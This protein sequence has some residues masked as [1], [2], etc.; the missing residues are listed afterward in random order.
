MLQRKA[1]STPWQHHPVFL[2]FL[3]ILLVLIGRATYFSFEKRATAQ[4]EYRQY[5]QEFLLLQQK[6]NDLEYDISKLESERGR[7]EEYRERFHVMRE[8]EKVIRVVEESN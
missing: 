4:D 2:L 8:G 7:E 6:K 1:K 3:F 5:H